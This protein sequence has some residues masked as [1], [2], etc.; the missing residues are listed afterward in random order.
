M[1]APIPMNNPAPTNHPAPV[2]G[3]TQELVKEH[4]AITSMLKVLLTVCKRM[5]AEAD[6]PTADLL[7]IVDFFSGFA[8][9]CHH[10]KE[11]LHLFPGMESAGIPREG[12]PIGVMLREHELG[13]KYIRGMKAA[14]AERTSGKSNAVPTFISDARAYASLL[15]LH[16]LKE[17][18]VLFPM[19]D[20]R[21]SDETMKSIARGFEDVEREEVGEGKHEHY[22]AVMNDLRARYPST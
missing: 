8:D 16:I 18:S 5:D 14:I 3:P 15:D 1:N 22:H 4:T 20:A 10:K 6:V 17:N 21:L 13:R 7:S 9:G 12:G 11:E 19:A 2:S